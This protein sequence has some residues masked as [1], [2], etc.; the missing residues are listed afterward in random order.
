LPVTTMNAARCLLFAS[1]LICSLASAS[2]ALAGSKPPDFVR[3]D[4]DASGGLEITDGIRVLNYLFLGAPA[5]PC[6]DAA[7]ADDD[8]I[9]RLT[10]A[11]LILNFLFLGGRP[12]SPPYP[13]CG[14]DPTPEDALGCESFPPC[15]GPPLAEFE[16]IVESFGLLDTL[17]GKGDI[18]CDVVGWDASYEGGPAAAAEL[19]CPHQALG[20]DA[21]NIYIADKD[22][23]AVRKVTPEG[24]IFT[25]VGTNVSG[26][27]SDAPGPG[28]ERALREPNGLWV[29]GDG[30]VYI[31]DTGNGKVRRLDPAGELVTLFSVPGGINTGRGLWVADDEQL[32]YVASRAVI[33]RWTPAAGVEPYAG[34]FSQLGNLAVASNGDII[35][36][37]RG[38]DAGSGHR[39]YRVSAADQS[40]TP[41]AGNGTPQ[42]GG[43][44]F[45]ALATG[46]DQVRGVWLLESGGYFLAT[47]AGSQ[48]WYVDTKGII[49]LF[50]DGA[51]DNVRAG[52]GEHFRTAGPK[53]SQIRSVS[54]D[55][56]GNVLVTENDFGHVRIVRRK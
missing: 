36:T 51:P 32:A 30:T 31:L 4:A 35:A 49:H 48:V 56:R 10:D 38:R 43:D 27:G 26:N 41:I 23:H 46:L 52:D 40:L 25:V 33:L 2:V 21:G 55:R 53:V 20:D 16:R 13:D 34:G 7:D 54:M 24:R 1:C 37:D 44:G 17:A 47:Q 45:P 18:G 9:L 39:V 42:G 50:L 5:P 28:T 6:L 19:S 11:I 14:A 12:P 15:G 3:G 8:G 29:L 22:A